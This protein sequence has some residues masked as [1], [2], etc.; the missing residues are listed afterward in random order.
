MVTG[1]E[2]K[3]YKWRKLFRYDTSHIPFYLDF[4]RLRRSSLINDSIVHSYAP[5]IRTREGNSNAEKVLRSRVTVFRIQPLLINLQPRWRPAPKT[6]KEKHG[7]GCICF[8]EHGR[9]P[10]HRRCVICGVVGHNRCSCPSVDCWWELYQHCIP[11][12][13]NSPCSCEH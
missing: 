12:R 10:R 4:I 2:L 8:R 6:F 13:L 3:N 5:R 11:D 9:P 7:N 1:T